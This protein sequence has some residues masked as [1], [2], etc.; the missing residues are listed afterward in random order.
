MKRSLIQLI[1]ATK[2]FE[3]ATCL[4]DV[5][6][7]L[8][9][10]EISAIDKETSIELE[11]STKGLETAL[12]ELMLSLIQLL[13]ELEYRGSA[14]SNTSKYFYQCYCTFYVAA[15]YYTGQFRKSLLV[16]RT[17]A[18]DILIEQGCH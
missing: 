7:S 12:I 6:L 11:T 1:R 8:H 3:I 4:I 15:K 10:L 18:K 9:D 14:V 2:Y 13:I 16:F 5:F 17:S